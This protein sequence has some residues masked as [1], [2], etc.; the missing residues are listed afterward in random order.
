MTISNQE[1]FESMLLDVLRAY[2]ITPKFANQQGAKALGRMHLAS[3]IA[4]MLVD[5]ENGNVPT[6]EQARQRVSDEWNRL[7]GEREAQVKEAVA[8]EMEKLNA[9][10]ANIRESMRRAQQHQ[11]PSPAGVWQQYQAPEPPPT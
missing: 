11:Q 6:L 10:Q 7:V 3:F 8:N 1:I 2:D 9:M 4:K 5:I